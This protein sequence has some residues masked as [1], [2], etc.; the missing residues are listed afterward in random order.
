M[1]NVNTPNKNATALS[2]RCRKMIAKNI[3]TMPCATRVVNLL[4]QVGAYSSSG[5]VSEGVDAL[6]AESGSLYC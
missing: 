3:P 5:P 4:T 6:S 1:G 2:S